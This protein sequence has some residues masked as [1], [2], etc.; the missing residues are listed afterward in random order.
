MRIGD[1]V[2]ALALG[3]LVAAGPLRH[4][5]EEPLLGRESVDGLS[6][7]SLVAS[8][9]AMYASIVPPRSA[10]SSPSVSLLLI[11]ISSTTVYCAY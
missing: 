10:T 11:L 4:A 5:D 2:H 7:W 6:F 1:G 3:A 9:H 8:F